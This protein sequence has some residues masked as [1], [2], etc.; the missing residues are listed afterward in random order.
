MEAPTVQ[1]ILDSAASAASSENFALAESLLREA[2]RLQ[3]STLGSEHPDLA[4][5]FNNLAIICEKENK[6][7]DAG[8]FYH[9]AFAIASASLGS[10]HPLVRKIGRA[11]V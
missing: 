1:D 4:S 6:L 10:E 11:H 5:T 3:E 2:A 8:E 9:R 7:A